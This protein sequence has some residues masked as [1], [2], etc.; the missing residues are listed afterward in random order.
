MKGGGNAGRPPCPLAWSVFKAAGGDL[1]L[2]VAAAAR[3][4]QAAAEVGKAAA[5]RLLGRLLLALA[6]L[7]AVDAQRRH[8][9]RHEA[10]ERDRLAAVL[11]DVDLAR[12]EPQELLV[13][14]AEQELLA[15]V[16]AHLRGE[17]LLLH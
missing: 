12:L 5:A 14:L 8:G 11:A 10:L 16:Q 15:I 17:D 6:L 2:G 4:A 7:L 9:A 3:V 1:D 13:D